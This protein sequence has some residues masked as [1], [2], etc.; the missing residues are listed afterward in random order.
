MKENLKC[1]FAS[2]TLIDCRRG[3]RERGGE[4]GKESEGRKRTFDWEKDELGLR[5]LWRKWGKK[6]QAD[7]KENFSILSPFEKKSFPA[8]I[9]RGD[10][11]V[12]KDIYAF[13]KIRRLASV[14]NAQRSG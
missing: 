14:A 3:I 1:D 2:L 7:R 9:P 5:H 10:L 6:T 8:P 11:F 12:E 4:R 13:P